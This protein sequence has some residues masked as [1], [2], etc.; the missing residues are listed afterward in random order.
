MTRVAI[1]G[2]GLFTPQESI[3]NDELVVAFNA[4]V[5]NYNTQHAGEIAGGTRI[6]LS[7]SSTEF[8]VK[9]SLPG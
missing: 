5:E 6:A 8:I 4:Y 2:S 7:P 3:S 9:A 1:S